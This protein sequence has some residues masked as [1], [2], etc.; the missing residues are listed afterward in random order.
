MITLKINPIQFDDQ[1][2][3]QAK[4]IFMQFF[5]D[6]VKEKFDYVIEYKFLPNIISKN[7]GNTLFT[8]FG[9]GINVYVN[10]FSQFPQEEIYTA[11]TL[12]SEL[13]LS[14]NI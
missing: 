2:Y 9:D 10:I 7:N 13:G 1:N 14:Y 6:Y 4:E 12:V 8:I 3:D 11:E 5:K